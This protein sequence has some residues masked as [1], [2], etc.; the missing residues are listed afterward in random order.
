ML[1][2]MT[3][4]L[5]LITGD[6]LFEQKKKISS[7]FKYECMHTHTQKKNILRR[8]LSK[9]CRQPNDENNTIGERFFFFFFIS[10]VKCWCH[11]SDGDAQCIF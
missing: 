8:H 2:V 7:L 10:E 4:K 9:T 6:A 5:S 3:G 1:F 11:C